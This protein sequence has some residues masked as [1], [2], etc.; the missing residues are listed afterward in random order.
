MKYARGV[1]AFLVLA[2]WA[3]PM[4]AQDLTFGAQVRSRYEFRKPAGLGDD[5]FVSM[6]ARADLLASLERNVR[7]F[8]QVQDVRFWGEETNTLTDFRA[9]N[10]DMHQAY[11]DVLHSG[12]T[13]FSGRVG[14]QEFNLADQ[15]LV[16]AV[17]WTQQA[18][19]FDGGVLTWD[20]RRGSLKF[21]G[22]KLAEASSGGIADDA[23]FAGAHG[24]FNVGSATLD[25]FGY[26]NRQLHG[27]MGPDMDTKEGTFGAR[28]ASDQ[29]TVRY[30]VEGAYQV[31]DRMGVD[32]KAF[33]V[34]GALGA[35]L[36]DNVTLTAWYDHLSGD[37]DL[38]DG[39][40]RV[41]NTLFATNHAFYGFADLFLNIPQNTGGRG[42]QDLALKGSFTATEDVSFGVD[43]HQ[44]LV[45][46]QG[47][48]T[49][50]NLG[51]EIDL[52]VRHRYSPQLSVQAGFSYVGRQDA[53][54]E[55][56]LLDEDM[57]WLYVMLN[58][59]L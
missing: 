9:E 4:Q 38:T 16:G 30:R 5:G 39:T 35:K 56:G 45:A 11:I 32:L 43:L 40:Q 18:R 59:K 46:R 23:D 42:L 53:M 17:D 22:F 21:F 2:A 15:R 13:G 36:G 55:L 54:T 34:A 10:F 31:G 19:A 51:Q 14:R 7:I 6:R 58:A 28:F 50:T 37:Q 25:A 33:M 8:V 12:P 41:F 1:V 29:G 52:T 48:L 24:R 47:T 49:T 3:V 27:S 57:K 26:Y 44:F 20:L